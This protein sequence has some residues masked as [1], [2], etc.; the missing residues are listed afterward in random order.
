MH[1]EQVCAVR[2]DRAHG[3]FCWCPATC[4]RR[5]DC[6]VVQQGSL[7]LC[8]MECTKGRLACFCRAV[9]SSPLSAGIELASTLEQGQKGF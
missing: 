5:A 3:R 4:A 6:V 1:G 2:G 8:G 7:V 9:H